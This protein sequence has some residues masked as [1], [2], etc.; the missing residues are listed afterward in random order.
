M[1]SH[2]EMINTRQWANC[3]FKAVLSISNTFEIIFKAQLVATGMK[4]QFVNAAQRPLQATVFM[5]LH[6]YKRRNFIQFYLL[7]QHTLPLNID[8][9]IALCDTRHSGPEC[10]KRQQVGVKQ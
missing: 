8:Y 2:N 10:V 6:K 1:Q 9:S 5:N 3:I 4:K 7:D